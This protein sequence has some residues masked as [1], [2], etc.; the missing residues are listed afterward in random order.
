MPLGGIE[1][2]LREFCLNMSASGIAVDLVISN[3][4]VTQETEQF[5]RSICRNVYLGHFG[6]SKLRHLWIISTAI[7]LRNKQYD[8]LYSNGQGDSIILF[9]KLIRY[10]K[11]WVHHHHTS[12]DKD[13]QLTWSRAYKQALKTADALIACSGRNALDMQTAL[14][15]E[16]YSIPCFSKE[17]KIEEAK[18]SSARLR[19]GYYGRLI[20]EKGIDLLCKL[21][22]DK[23]LNHIEFHIWGEGDVYSRD[24]FSQFPGVHYHGAFSGKKELKRVLNSLDAYLLLST[25]QEGLPIA[26]LEV[27]STGLP[28]LATDRGGIRDLVCDEMATRVIPV[29]SH[30]DEIKK[31]ISNLASDIKM[32]LVSGNK[33]KKFY[34]QKFS[35]PVLTKKWREVLNVNSYDE[36]LLN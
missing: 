8:A 18:E 30:F 11:K 24:F 2:H 3:A 33:Q 17:I 36:K 12:G 16:V 29:D 9:S 31:A 7:K 22:K 20:P 6:R 15:R 27:M 10:Y 26:L 5:F 21:S 14:K 25:N 34:L 4:V 1:S 35:S 23:D 32:N 19:F 13:D 28:W